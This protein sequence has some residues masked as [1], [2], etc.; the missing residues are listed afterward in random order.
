LHLLQLPLK[1]DILYKLLDNKSKN[2]DKK[3]DFEY[4]AEEKQGK[5]NKYFI[6]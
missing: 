4:P 5:K 1:S 6:Y 3:S 2:E